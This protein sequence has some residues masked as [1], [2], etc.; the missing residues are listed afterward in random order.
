[1]QAKNK[2]TCPDVTALLL[3]PALSYLSEAM[4]EGKGEE[5]V[6]KPATRLSR[7]ENDFHPQT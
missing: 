5:W 3:S 2:A 1:M 7:G 4:L 6:T